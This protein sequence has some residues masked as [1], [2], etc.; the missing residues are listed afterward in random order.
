MLKSCSSCGRIHDS[1]HICAQ[2]QRAINDRQRKYKTGREIDKFRNTSAWKHKREEIKERDHYLCQICIRKLY[3]TLNQYTYDNL[4]V[5]HAI[6]LEQD[7]DRRL[8]NE[9]LI[10]T[11]DFHHEKMESGEIPTAIVLDIIKEQESKCY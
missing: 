6:P 8:D 4:S 2:K 7:F 1:K 5:H 3:D 11:C 10:T 9:N